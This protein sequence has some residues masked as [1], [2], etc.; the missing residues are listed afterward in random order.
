M[1]NGTPRDTPTCDHSPGLLD[2]DHG[3]GAC[4]VIQRIAATLPA[5]QVGPTKGN[6]NEATTEL[7]FA[8]GG[9]VRVDVTLVAYP[10]TAMMKMV[11]AVL[12][13][14]MVQAGLAIDDLKCHD[15]RIEITFTDG[16]SVSLGHVPS[17][18]TDLWRWA[19]HTDGWHVAPAVGIGAAFDAYLARRLSN[20]WA[21]P[22]PPLTDFEVID[23]LVQGTLPPSRCPWCRANSDHPE[24]HLRRA[25]VAT[26]DVYSFG[27]EAHITPDGRYHFHD[28]P[29]L[30]ELWCTNGHEW[31]EMVPHP[32]N[33]TGCTY[34]SDT[35]IVTPV[36]PEVLP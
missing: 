13:P 19:D 24:V 29:V 31:R 17:V 23:V 8:D 25:A 6:R 2:S 26:S 11:T 33:V 28:Q 4:G 16:T 20:H 27:S 10:K 18:T 7:R 30:W 5:T 32:C 21:E 36:N 34:G 15:N 35:P 12:V 9:I 1:G 22:A 3:P 14:R